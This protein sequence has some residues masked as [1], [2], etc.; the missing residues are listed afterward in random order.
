MSD[1]SIPESGFLTW[2][3]LEKPH[4]NL[5][6]T[7]LYHVTAMLISDQG[8]VEPRSNLDLVFC[9]FCMLAGS[10]VI[11]V[12]FGQM[13]LIISNMN[14][15]TS[16]FQRKMERLHSTMKY[17]GIPDP[18]QQRIFRYYTY[19]WEEHRTID[20]NP[21]AFVEELS[22][23]LSAEVTLFLRRRVIATNL[24]FSKC[25]AE[26]LHDIVL[27]MKRSFYM[28]GDYVLR[29]GAI[30]QGLYLVHTGEIDV[31]ITR[32][33]ND[34]NKDDDDDGVSDDDDG[35]SD[36]DDEASERTMRVSILGPGAHF[37]SKSLWLRKQELASVV[38]R[39][40]CEI[41]ILERKKFA[42]LCAKHKGLTDRVLYDAHGDD[43]VASS[44]K[45]NPYNTPTKK[46]F[47][48]QVVV[49]QKNMKKKEA[50][51]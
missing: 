39:T 4:T 20:G 2:G 14:A 1:E 15:Q 47:S 21:G 23:N 44:S 27:A 16:G 48:P 12:V 42:W 22:V 19:L 25:Y 31:L 41:L 11:S 32:P 3:A 5:Y 28:P 33:M 26:E 50:G 9:T 51:A 46:R 37:G 45:S 35:V 34:D 43:V 29:E 49:P 24:I 6:L 8:G 18:L 7:T 40:N 38:A 36:D 10:V 30:G 13:A 17:G